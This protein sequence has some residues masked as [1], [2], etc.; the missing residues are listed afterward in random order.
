M[1]FKNLAEI[2]LVGYAYRV[3]NITNLNISVF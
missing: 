3:G 1:L 2:Q